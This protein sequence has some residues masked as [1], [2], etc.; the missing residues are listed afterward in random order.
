MLNNRVP[1]VDL[2]DQ[3]IWN[4]LLKLLLTCW[5]LAPWKFYIVDIG[6]LDIS[7]ICG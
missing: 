4:H 7:G 3:I 1:R 6:D 5:K 2:Y